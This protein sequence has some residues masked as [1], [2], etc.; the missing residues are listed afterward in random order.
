LRWFSRGFYVVSEHNDEIHLADIRFGS[1]DAG[2]PESRRFIFEW[3][4]KDTED[5]PGHGEIYQ[6]EFKDV[7]FDKL[8]NNLWLRLIGNKR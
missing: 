7:E 1:L 3:L 5:R 6:L 2:Q 4:L 8:L